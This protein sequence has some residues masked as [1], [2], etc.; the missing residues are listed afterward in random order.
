MWRSTAGTAAL[1]TPEK[2]QYRAVRSA[3]LGISRACRRQL[4]AR[5]T[6]A[7]H[8]LHVDYIVVVHHPLCQGERKEMQIFLSTISL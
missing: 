4:F 5:G 8:P 6:A 2:V 1:Y 3:I 7:V